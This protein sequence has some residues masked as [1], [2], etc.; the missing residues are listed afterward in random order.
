MDN[1][2]RQLIEYRMGQANA[3]LAALATTGYHAFYSHQYELLAYFYVDSVLQGWYVDHM[4][5]LKHEATHA[6]SLYDGAECDLLR[7]L[8][9]YLRTGK[10]IDPR[11]IKAFGYGTEDFDQ[12]WEV[13]SKL[14][15][16]GD[17]S[18]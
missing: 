8:V 11:L 10:P 12:V 14:D 7:E 6:P 1:R 16:I 2:H 4:T 17:K 9:A 5:G 18:A 15:L 13:V 3:V